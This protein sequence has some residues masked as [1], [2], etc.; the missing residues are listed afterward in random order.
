[1]RRAFFLAMAFAGA[2]EAAD[3]M[4]A[5]RLA[6]A[7]DPVYLAARA[8]AEA[9]RELVP[10]ARAGLLP[11]LS[12]S[13]FRGQN[14]T[15]QTTQGFV[16]GAPSTRHFDYPSTAMSLNLRQPLVK[17]AGI[18]SYQSA[19]AQVAAAEATLA[20]EA[21]A[22]T[23]RVAGAYFE[24]LVA[25]EKV[26]SVLAQKE[27]Y[28]AQLAAAE[29]GLA[30]GFG[31]RTDVD[32]AKA[33]L[34]V[35]AALEIDARHAVRV[36]ERALEGIVSR[37]MPADALAALDAT[38][39]RLEPPQPPDIVAWM[40]RAVQNNPELQA[41]RATADAAQREID[42][43][44]AAHLP[45]LDLVASRS[46]NDSDTN[47][48]IG[49]RY[50]TNSIGVQLS[51]PLFS[52][53][54]TASTVRQAHANLD[55][56]RQQYEAGRRLVEVDVEKHFGAVAKGIARV[57][58]LE[59]AERSAQQSVLS[60]RKGVEAGVRNSVDVLNAVQQLAATQ[61][62]LVQ[63]RYAYAFDRL[64]LKAVAGTLGEPDIATV[65]AWLSAR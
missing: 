39:L 16:A 4:D 12:A 15:A 5:Y 62:E 59:Q 36:A 24:V 54:H 32:D 31:T 23:L 61:H 9:A 28:R 42:K 44:R 53:G 17:L 27:A 57:G 40:A 34:D 58:A 50:Y 51:I 41:L 63:A 18:A 3:L 43:N 22:L 1:M 33:R 26:H 45:T 30:S 35:A 64:R 56:A 48:S 11:Q 7:G 8:T 65:N 6:I 37:R 19:E 2:G 20:Q 60:S 49:T 25:R 10:Q 29:R 55:K 38:R 47:T 14:S 13:A 21:Q 46:K 52:G